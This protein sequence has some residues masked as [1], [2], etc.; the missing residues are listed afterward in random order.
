M[1]CKNLLPTIFLALTTFTE[2]ALCKFAVGSQ[3][4]SHLSLLNISAALTLTD[5]NIT[6]SPPFTV[7]FHTTVFEILR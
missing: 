7:I 1:C 2:T 6:I 5:Y 3:K 4:L